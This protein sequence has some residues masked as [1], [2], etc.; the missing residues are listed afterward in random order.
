[1]RLYLTLARVQEALDGTWL[2][3]LTML[4]LEYVDVTLHDENVVSQHP[5]CRD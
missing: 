2:F 3:N 5:G 1:M 4:W